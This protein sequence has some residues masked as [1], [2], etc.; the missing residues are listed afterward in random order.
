[1]QGKSV[2]AYLD[3]KKNQAQKIEAKPVSKIYEEYV[4][5]KPK[6]NIDKERTK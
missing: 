3:L 4:E 5:T 1:M 2:K 6:T